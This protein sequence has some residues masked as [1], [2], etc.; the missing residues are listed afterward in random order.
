MRPVSLAVCA[1]IA[2]LAGLIALKAPDGTATAWM[3]PGAMPSRLELIREQHLPNVPLITQDG[4]QV[5]FYDDLVKGHAVAINFMF[6]SCRAA[7]PLT[8]ANIRDV[9]E[10]L[11]VRLKQPVSFL[12]ISLN[13]EFDS[14][15]VLHAYAEANGA[16][17][18]WTFLTGARADVELLRRSLGAYDLDPELDKIPTQHTG[19]LIIGNEPTGRWKAIAALSHPV[20]LRQA[21]ERVVLPVTEWQ[22]GAVAVNA[23]PFADNAQ[24]SIQSR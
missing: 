14:P 11:R 19:L 7:C 17:P 1:A 5:R 16:G 23:V 2:G 12:S 15:E 18:G 20:R 4:R 9:Q 10:A 21:I 3:A 13:P 8:A 22:T 6:T 24:A